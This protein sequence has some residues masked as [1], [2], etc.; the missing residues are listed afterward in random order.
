MSRPC[1]EV[2]S[3]ITALLYASATVASQDAATDGFDVLDYV[4]PFIGTANGGMSDERD[5]RGP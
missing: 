2:L 5:H 1:A 3:V 4:D